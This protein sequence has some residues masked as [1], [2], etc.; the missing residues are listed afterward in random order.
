MNSGL[1]T[2]DLHGK[3]RYQAK[4]IIDAALRRSRGVYRLRL[5][6]GF[7]RGTE[8][9]DFIRAEYAGRPGVLRLDNSESGATTLVLREF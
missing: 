8:L 9:R 5:V 7:N 2:I 4:I 6:H 1:V 3:N